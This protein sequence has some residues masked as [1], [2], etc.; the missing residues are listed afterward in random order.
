MPPLR[1]DAR[2]TSAQWLRLVLTP[3]IGPAA[4][5]RLLAAFGLPEEIFT[6]GHSR[7]SAAL[8]GPRAQALLRADP[9]R[10]AAVQAALD[11]AD[12][13]DHHL[14][15]FDD[16]RYPPRLL[17]I[18]DPPPVLFVHGNPD[19]L[20]RPSLAIV[21]SRHATQSGMGH[22]LDFAHALGDAGLTIVSGLAQG[23]DAAAHRG[24]LDT[25]AGTV[26][27]IG[28]GIDLVYPVGHR[29]LSEA[30]SHSGALVSE[31][32]LGMP[33]LRSN[34]PRRNR[35]IAG[36]T[37]ATL[38]V[39]AARRSGS[40]ITARQATEAGRDV[41]AI[42]GS[43]HSPL[44]KGCHQLIRDGAKLVES[45]EDVLVELRGALGSGF[46]TTVGAGPGSTATGRTGSVDDRGEALLDAMGFD[47]IDVDELIDRTG[48][49]AGEIGASLLALE[50]D[51]R[52]ERL[53]DGR[54]ARC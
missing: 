20:T 48:R 45:V 29:A 31:L 22:A 44:S 36:L 9:E 11:W 47:P 19:A 30:I 35:L 1:D 17:E 13:E 18:S 33:V 26:A 25:Q 7:L 21:G 16:P 34:F 49:P 8:D 5:R 51:G 10:D 6:A 15:A 46:G 52:V 42:P 41:M 54:F 2:E 28:T 50:F 39:E 12:A 3:N 43:I 24:A 27:V 14:L 4:V 23:I 32:P 37:L 38:V 53:V 40:L